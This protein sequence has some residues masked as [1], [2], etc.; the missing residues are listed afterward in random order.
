MA[1]FQRNL[2][3][4]PLFRLWTLVRFERG[5]LKRLAFFQVLQS[6]TYLPFYAGVGYLI[7]N[8]LQNA[9]LTVGQKVMWVGVYGFANLALWPVHAWFTVRAFAAGQE[10]I[11]SATARLRRLLVDHL[12]RM[13]IGFFTRKG[14][15]ALA[16]QVTVDLGKVE[17]FLSNVVGGLIV[18]LTIGAGALA[19]LFAMNW[20]LAA[21]T[22]GAVP[23]QVLI[24]RVMGN[25]I[26]ALNRRV[27]ESGES[28]SSQVVEFISGM[29]V[30]KSLGNEDIAAASLATAI[31]RIRTSGLDASVTMR[32]VMMGMQMIGEFMGVVIWCVGGLMFIHGTLPLGTLVAFT[33]LL[34]F[35]R[36]GFNAYFNAYDA[37]AQARPGLES[38][39]S[40]LDSDELEGFRHGAKQ[41][42]LR[43]EIVLRD[44][45]FVYPKAENA[46][47]LRDVNL[48]IPAGQHVGLVGET[49]AG[50]STLL[51]LIVGFYVPQHGQI[52]YDGS[53]LADVGLR[54]LRRA[55][56]IMG[57][58]AFLWNTSVRENIRMGRPHA[59][60]AEVEQ[61]A[62][63]AQAHEFIVRL[64]R[65]YDTICGERGSRLSG[66][67]KQR[68]A[69][70]RV[71]L[72]NPSIVILDEPTSA[73]DLSTEARLQADLEELC[74]G[75]TAFLVAHR[76]ST[77]RAVDRV[78]VFRQGRIIEDGAPQELLKNPHSA[79]ARL[80]ALQFPSKPEATA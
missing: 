45:T 78:L 8:I 42:S 14:A 54:N 11:R 10:L 57:Q 44:V 30:T 22:L 33:A 70:A 74:R 26:S 3:P 24:I 18:Q 39:L 15:G 23:L 32:W 64:D 43:G 28:F 69:L 40:I 65:G 46:P 50:K 35:V 75:R 79:F 55:T 73:L 5:L 51:D 48:V 61:A 4:A 60:D 9:S 1:N 76:L 53:P 37:W 6:L 17:A 62:R 34:G 27:Q 56:A 38:I 71:F 58:E 25:R 16:N 29:R 31:D 67:Q 66:G 80:S 2:V 49:G 63:Q 47:V 12:Q 68:I 13:S 59:T 7:N 77:L 72:R 41:I 21:I 19:W 52:L 36:L 20:K